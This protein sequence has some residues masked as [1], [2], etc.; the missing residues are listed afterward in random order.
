MYEITGNSGKRGSY[1]GELT[2]VLN[3]DNSQAT[4]DSSLIG[5]YQH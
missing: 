1:A 5:S 3:L 4:L 2:N